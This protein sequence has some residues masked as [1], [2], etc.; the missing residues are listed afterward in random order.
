MD[1]ELIRPDLAP[2]HLGEVDDAARTAVEVHLCACEPCLRQY[3]AI[4]RSLEIGGG[5]PSAAARERLRRAVT[6]EMAAGSPSG[7]PWRRWERPLAVVLAGAAVVLSTL[8]T[9]ALASGPA[10]PPH[11]WSSAGEP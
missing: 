9:S 2:Y 1:C 5:R 10:G 11:G 3:L 7:K 8:A 4:K 6:T